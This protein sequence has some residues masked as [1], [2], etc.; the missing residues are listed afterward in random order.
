RLCDAEWALAP[1]RRA[2]L[3]DVVAQCHRATAVGRRGAERP[4]RAGA[5]TLVGHGLSGI[6]RAAIVREP[7]HAH[8]HD[9][10]TRRVTHDDDDRSLET[11]ARHALLGVARR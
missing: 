7:A 9:G 11:L 5:T 6:D 10:R 2:E 3:G 1:G 4:R 8:T